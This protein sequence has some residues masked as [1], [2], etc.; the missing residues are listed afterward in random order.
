MADSFIDQIKGVN[1]A[2]AVF[3]VLFG[4]L[5]GYI[6]FAILFPIFEATILPRLPID[7]EPLGDPFA[8]NNQQR[9]RRRQAG[10]RNRIATQ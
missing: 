1:T 4:G 5:L 8:G 9:R 7:I 10:T 3:L 6:A 2:F